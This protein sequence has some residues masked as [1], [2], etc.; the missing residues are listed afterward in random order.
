MAYGMKGFVGWGFEGLNNWGTAANAV[1]SF[2]NFFEALSETVTVAQDRYEFRNISN[3]LAEQDDSSG[4]F[5]CAGQIVAA[6]HANVIPMFLKA[7]V[8]TLVNCGGVA[9]ARIISAIPPVVDVSVNQPL[10]PYSFEINADITSS[11]LFVGGQCSKLELNVAANQEL[12]ITSDWIFQASS[13]AMVAPSTPAFPTADAGQPFSFDTCSVSIG[14]AGVDYFESFT[15]SIDN[16][17]EGVPRLN[18]SK[19]IA[20]VRRTGAQTVRLSGVVGFEIE[21][22]GEYQKFLNQTETAMSFYF[23]KGNS[24]SLFIDLP[25]LVYSAYPL[26]M[27]GREKL[28]VQIEAIARTP[29]AAGSFACRFII[30]QDNVPSSY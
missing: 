2:T 22:I 14:G 16:K 7:A 10:P 23:T 24:H 15:L 26:T 25:R 17:L 21:N 29:T 28:G 8:G 11:Q 30:V 9:F 5:R 3:A 20:R 6:A 19:N 13:A 27:P 1:G 4:M 12:R 18:G